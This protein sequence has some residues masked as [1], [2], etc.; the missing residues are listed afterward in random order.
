MSKKNDEQLIKDF[1]Q[2]NQV[3]YEI[4]YNRY[5]DGFTILCIDM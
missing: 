4:L 3:A 1:Q 2:G 5:K